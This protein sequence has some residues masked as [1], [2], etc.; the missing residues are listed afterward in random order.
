MLD[1]YIQHG[2]RSPDQSLSGWGEDG[3]VIPE[4]L[5]IH[6]IYGRKVIYFG[7][8]HSAQIA[9]ALTG[10]PFDSDDSLTMTFE[11]DFLL[12]KFSDGSPGYFADWGLAPTQYFRSAPASLPIQILAGG[13]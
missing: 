4:C 2:R 3:P 12:A 11:G 1:L 7:S 13:S 9:A 10:W 6:S 8:A 5:G